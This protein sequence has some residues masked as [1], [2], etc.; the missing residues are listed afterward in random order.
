MG[1]GDG[2]PVA[3]RGFGVDQG[4]CHARAGCRGCGGGSGCVDSSNGVVAYG[5]R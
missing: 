5:H 1:V 4:P 3:T 2:A